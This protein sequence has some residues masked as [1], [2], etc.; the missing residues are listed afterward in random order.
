MRLLLDT[1]IL[2]WA[3][4]NDSSLPTAARALIQDESNEVFFSAASVWEIS[5]KHALGRAGM[6]VSGAEALH[7][8]HVSGYRELTIRAAHAAVELKS[9]HADPFDR[10]LVSQALA[11]P[12]RLVTHD[13]TVARY[14]DTV[15]LV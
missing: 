3:I 6:P 12:L 14:S 5:I 1:H 7:W 13:S 11:E 4:T 9:I 2:L 15:I 10:M 8:F